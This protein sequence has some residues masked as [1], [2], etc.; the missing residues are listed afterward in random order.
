MISMAPWQVFLRQPA[1]PHFFF[2]AGADPFRGAEMSI[3]DDGI[4]VGCLMWI[5][6]EYRGNI[7]GDPIFNP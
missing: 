6:W 7:V 4:F 5:Q 1:G 2:S 3:N